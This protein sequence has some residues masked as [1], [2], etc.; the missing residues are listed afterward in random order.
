MLPIILAAIAGSSDV[1]SLLGLG[2]FNAHITGN[3][4]ILA[5][6]LATSQGAGVALVL[7][8]PVFLVVVVLLGLKVARPAARPVTLLRLFL[9]LQLALLIGFLI[10]GTLA[11][12][13]VDRQALVPI[14]AALV[15]VAAMAVQHVI[16][17]VS[18]KGAPATAV[19]TINLTRLAV[20]LDAVATA[21]SP[22]A[23]QAARG[24]AGRTWP[25]L[26][27]FTLG[28][29]IG[30]LCF[31]GIGLRAVL[32][33]VALAI[34]ALVVGWRAHPALSASGQADQSKLS[35]SD[36]GGRA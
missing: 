28:A 31:A 9:G 10:F 5:G 32:L 6:T 3:I 20:D 19:M 15:G 7:S 36:E 24:R 4:V 35:A 16:L 8:L 22:D 17:Q 33:P 14:V 25:M 13:H 29:G 34:V 2:L 11:E 23:V 12:P 30:A 1:I 18:F 27:A 21:P 26:V